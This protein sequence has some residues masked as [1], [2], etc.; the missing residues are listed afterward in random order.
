MQITTSKLDNFTFIF[1]IFFSKAG[2][3][4]TSSGLF[5]LKSVNLNEAYGMNFIDSQTL[6]EIAFWIEPYNAGVP[7]CINLSDVNE[8]LAF[9]ECKSGRPCLSITTN[10]DFSLLFID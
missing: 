8:K 3:Y 9:N 1:H 10:H 6:L 7:E 5:I 4:P 2:Q